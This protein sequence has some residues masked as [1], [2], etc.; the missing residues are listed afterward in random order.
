MAEATEADIR[1]GQDSR[2]ADV[3]SA[4]ILYWLNVAKNTVLRA[5]VQVS[6][7]RFGE[8]QAYKTY[9]LLESTGCI[10]NE[11]NSESV[12]DV[13][14]GLDSNI[15]IG[16]AVFYEDRYNKELL[17]VLGADFRFC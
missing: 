17:N 8:L 15:A 1:T 5:G 12:S 16:S 4:T 10:P 2:L 14:V 11:I 7:E 6:H 13:S 9:S 3:S